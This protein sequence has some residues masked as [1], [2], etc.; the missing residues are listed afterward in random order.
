[1]L[2]NI[3]LGAAPYIH[4]LYAENPY[5]TIVAFCKSRTYLL[6]SSAMMYR[7]CLVAACFDRCVLTS[8][9]TRLRNFANVHIAYR[10]IAMI[11][12]IWLVLPVHTIIFFNLKGERCFPTDNISVSLYHS[13][14]TIISGSILPVSIMI[15]C[16]VIIHRNLLLKRQRRRRLA[17]NS[18]HNNESAGRKR[19]QQIVVMLLLQALVFVITQTPWMVTYIYTTATM[20]ISNKSTDRLAIEGFINFIADTIAFL[21]PVLSFYLYTLAS[22]TFRDE[23]KKLLHYPGRRRQ[24][25]NINRAIPLAHHVPVQMLPSS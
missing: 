12:I 19:D 5:T 9:S 21:L 23:L 6:Q 25:I 14:Y 8:T 20:Y 4:S 13:I 1:M 11:I 17:T 24:I 18:Q 7:W 3:S 2:I 22:R 16:A 15:V 10:V